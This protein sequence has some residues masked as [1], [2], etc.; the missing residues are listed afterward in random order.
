[1]ISK[2]FRQKGIKFA[3]ILVFQIVLLAGMVLSSYLVILQGEKMTLQV[4]PVDP[5]SLFQ[6]DYVILNYSFN[7]LDLSEISHDLVP[8]KVQDQQPVYLAFS[9]K[10]DIWAPDF[11]TQ[12]A[13]KVKGRTYIKGKI[14]YLSR[15]PMEPEER[16]D[17]VDYNSLPLTML[18]ANWGIEQYYVPEGQGK[19]IEQQIQDGIVYAQVSVYHGKSRVTGL[20]TE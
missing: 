16:P 1:M 3:A 14:L 18:R 20:L 9:Q 15:K 6:G 4:E 13:A 10:N 7:N 19:V 5:R 2:I 12:D 17:S 11:V 8:E